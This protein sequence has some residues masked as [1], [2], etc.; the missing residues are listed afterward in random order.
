M[1]NTATLVIH[2]FGEADDHKEAL[3]YLASK[4]PQLSELKLWTD[5]RKAGGDKIIC[6]V[7][8][9]MCSTELLYGDFD[10]E[11]MFDEI[12]K[13]PWHSAIIPLVVIWESDNEL[14]STVLIFDTTHRQHCSSGRRNRLVS[15]VEV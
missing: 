9:A 10:K 15:R 3:E 13:A 14:V 2:V 6:Q 5:D 12:A 8:F 4:V 7:S 11:V 1:A